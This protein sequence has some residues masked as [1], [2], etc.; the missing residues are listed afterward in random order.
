MHPE[1]K[2]VDGAD[3]KNCALKLKKEEEHSP[4]IWFKPS[5]LS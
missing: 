4:P 1:L 5:P 3:Q 2:D